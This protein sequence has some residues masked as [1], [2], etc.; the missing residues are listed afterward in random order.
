MLAVRAKGCFWYAM[1]VRELQA[2]PEIQSLHPWMWL[3]EGPYETATLY[4]CALYWALSIMYVGQDLNSP[5]WAKSFAHLCRHP[6]LLASA[7]VGCRTNLKGIN[8]HESRQCLYVDVMVCTVVVAC[9]T[10]SL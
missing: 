3:D 8:A 1:V 2:T 9:R 6:R 10:A 5:C 4:V 7:A